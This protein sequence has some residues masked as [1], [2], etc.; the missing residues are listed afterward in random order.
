MENSTSFFYFFN[1]PFPNHIYE[2]DGIA[3]C[4][5]MQSAMGLFKM[6]FGR[7]NNV[8]SDEKYFLVIDAIMA[9]LQSKQSKKHEIG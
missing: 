9:C 7:Q 1:E 3:A 2:S 8:V 6:I 4:I 5:H